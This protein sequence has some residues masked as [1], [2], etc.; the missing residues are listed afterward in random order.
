M[1]YLGAKKLCMNGQLEIGSH[2]TPKMRPAFVERPQAAAEEMRVR[3]SDWPFLGLVSGLGLAAPLE[4]LRSSLL[5]LA[6]SF[7]PLYW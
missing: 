5:P 6:P 7:A 2:S 1:H 3:H 4:I